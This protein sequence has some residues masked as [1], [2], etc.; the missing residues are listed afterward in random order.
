M[1]HKKRNI[2]SNPPPLRN[3][4]SKSP[5]IRKVYSPSFTV[6]LSDFQIAKNWEVGQN[7][8]I[9]VKQTGLTNKTASFKI[10]GAED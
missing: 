8:T 4:G 3:I 5:S 10:V 9:K 7:Y 1:P 2:Y 6:N